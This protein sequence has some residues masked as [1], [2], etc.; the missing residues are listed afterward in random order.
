M[1]AAAPATSVKGR[2]PAPERLE[3]AIVEP[4]QWTEVAVPPCAGHGWAGGWRAA[5]RAQLALPVVTAK[6]TVVRRR[7]EGCN[8]PHP[9]L[10][11]SRQGGRRGWRGRQAGLLG[12]DTLV[13]VQ[14]QPAAV[15]VD[16]ADDDVGAAAAVVV[17]DVAADA[18][19]AADVADAAVAAVAA[20]DVVAVAVAVAAAVK[21]VPER[22]NRA[23]SSGSGL[24]HSDS[25]RLPPVD[26]Q[27]E[28]WPGPP[29]ALHSAQSR[30]CPT[31]TAR[32]GQAARAGERRPPCPPPPGCSG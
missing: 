21:V 2:P 30:G 13:P 8:L 1:A 7:W 26:A 15:D 27:V 6:T 10:S 25:G 29:H 19:D 23:C 4:G 17:V 28:S 12:N 20:A 31:N 9:G 22:P 18:A 32:L 14:Q 16:E 11:R 24:W 5:R 3:A